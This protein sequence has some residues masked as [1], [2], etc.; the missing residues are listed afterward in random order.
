MVGILSYSKLG[1]TKRILNE[2]KKGDTEKTARYETDYGRKDLFS[3]TDTGYEIAVRFW[4]DWKYY[5]H[6]HDEP[7]EETIIKLDKLCKKYSN[8]GREINWV[9]GNKN[10]IYISIN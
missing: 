6:I 4:G 9:Y 1:I 10:W 2:L 8:N 5:G 3:K 7:T